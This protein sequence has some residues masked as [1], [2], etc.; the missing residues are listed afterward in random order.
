MALRHR[1]EGGKV[2]TG[3]VQSHVFNMVCTVM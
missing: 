3:E 1:G 2:Y